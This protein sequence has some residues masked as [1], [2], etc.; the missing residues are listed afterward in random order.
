MQG[1][2]ARRH[3]AKPDGLCDRA[4]AGVTSMKS[5]RD[6]KRFRTQAHRHAYAQT[7]TRTRVHTEKMHLCIKITRIPYVSNTRTHPCM[8]DM[9]VGNPCMLDMLVGNMY[10]GNMYNV[11]ASYHGWP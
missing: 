6:A 5:R 1:Q 10:N 8:L 3:G 4:R 11:S 7:Y 2:A 9:L